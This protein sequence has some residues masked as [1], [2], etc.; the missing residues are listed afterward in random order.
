M[1][2]TLFPA[3][4]FA[5]VFPDDTILNLAQTLGPEIH[6]QD[7][8]YED[9]RSVPDI[10]VCR[11]EPGD[12]QLEQSPCLDFGSS[13]DAV[14]Q[15]FIRERRSRRHSW[16]PDYDDELQRV[17]EV[18]KQTAAAEEE[19]REWYRGYHT[20]TASVS[21]P[22]S[23]TLA[24]PLWAES[25]S[26]STSVNAKIRPFANFD[27]NLDVTGI[28]DGDPCCDG[29]NSSGIDTS[30]CNVC[31][32]TFCDA[33][34]RM[35]LAHRTGKVFEVPHERTPRYVANTIRAV[36][37]PEHNEDNCKDLHYRDMLTSWFGVFCEDNDRPLLRDY[38]RFESLMTSVAESQPDIIAFSDHFALGA[39]YPSIVSFVGTK[40]AGK[41]SLI[42]LLIDLSTESGETFDTPV[43]GTIGSSSP[44][45]TDVHLYLDPTTADSDHPILYADCEGLEGGE[46][47]PVG[48]RFKRDVERQARQHAQGERSL[49]DYMP[50]HVAERELCWADA[51]WRRSREYAVSQ[52][53]PRLLYA[54][55]DAIV[56]VLK[57]S[58]YAFFLAI[59]HKSSDRSYRVVEGVL[60]RLVN[61]AAAALEKSSNQP[62]LPHAIIALNA[63]ENG[64]SPELW[65]VDTATERL[66]QEM[67]RTV[68]QNEDFKKFAQFWRER[69]RYIET[70]EQLLFS[71]YSSIKV[72]RIPTTGR[73]NLIAAQIGKLTG[74]I[75][76]ACQE[77]GRGKAERR[78]LLNAEDMPPYLQYAFDH[79][80]KNLDLPFDF[81]QAS[82]TNSPIPTDFGGNILKLAI[83]LMNTWENRLGA[84]AIFEEVAVMVASCIMLDADRQKI[85]GRGRCVNVQSGH[86]KGH[87]S[88]SGRVLAHGDYLST[89]SFESFREQFANDVY[90]YL[91]EL[92]CNLPQI[93]DRHSNQEDKAATELHKTKVLRPF[94]THSLTVHSESVLLSHTVCFC[95]LF[96][97][98][99]H[100]LPCGHVLC[101]RCLKDYGSV[102]EEDLIRIWGCPI[103][104]HTRLFPWNDTFSSQACALR[105]PH[106][107]VRRVSIQ[108]TC[109]GGI[110]GISELGILQQIENALGGALP[111][112]SFLD[113][114]VGTSTG[115]IISLGLA[116]RGWSVEEC[117]HKF[118]SDNTFSDV[119]KEAFSEQA[120]LFGGESP[121]SSVPPIKVAVTTAAASS[122]VV[123]SNYNRIPEVSLPYHFERPEKASA[124][125]KIWEAARATSA[126]PLYFRPF[127]HPTTKQSYHD[128]GI[129]HNNPINV[130]EQTHCCVHG[131]RAEQSWRD[132]RDAKTV[133]S[134]EKYRYIRLNTLLRD[135]LPRLDDVSKMD[136][137]R[138]ETRKQ[139][140][141]DL[142]VKKLARRLVATS[143][144]FQ[145]DAADARNR[146]EVSVTDKTGYIRCRLPN[147]DPK[148]A[149][150]GNF[151]FNAV[152]VA[153]EACFLISEEGHGNG[154]LG[155][156]KFDSH[157]LEQMI[158]KCKFQLRQVRV[159]VQNNIAKTNIALCYNTED[160]FP[161]SG[162]PRCLSA[163]TRISNGNRRA[164]TA[165]SSTRWAAR[166]PSQRQRQWAPAQRA[167]NTRAGDLLSRF[168]H[169]WHILGNATSLALQ[170][171]SRRLSLGPSQS[172]LRAQV[173]PS[174]QIQELE[175]TEIEIVAEAQNQDPGQVYELE[176]DI[177]PVE[178]E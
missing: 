121:D 64:L 117:I 106:F 35:Q 81:V 51:T 39:R 63:S 79:F 116:A 147:D 56:F 20:G 156:I 8:G 86:T 17:F 58:K 144:Y 120:C 62:V 158:R 46:R 145:P 172:S 101:T 61:W 80:S 100:A 97:I 23:H 82:F 83:Q 75:Q 134:K 141:N 88:K 139:F 95:C 45:S 34:W 129:Y 168:A 21:S 126:A 31:D 159:P 18:S 65:D 4:E 176:G 25:N 111:I 154:A 96:D 40:G 128:G 12:A 143:F 37:T 29:C 150:L 53:Y 112:Q 36:F 68:Y 109:V 170:L 54:F 137:L 98:P 171:E 140:E 91:D 43:V 177:P 2:D 52:L 48:A 160:K 151:I 11:P 28:Q 78:M 146:D 72:V 59:S 15:P 47:D 41:S 161:I 10:S 131:L 163:D 104:G 30:Y 19:R 118:E 157:L 50:R 5:S 175:S 67:S 94:F 165:A 169:E 114:V 105:Y 22:V 107:D 76:S 138:R 92:L 57:N 130:A 60:V 9:S 142:D 7:S 90:T 26:A 153:N 113:L 133:R 152:G 3:F 32:Y 119:L 77:S 125:L 103:D 49:F 166:T 162:F 127:S 174:R 178:L 132:Y 44:T 14:T 110:R 148:I 173:N 13:G 115:G 93:D 6:E 66:M 69:G 70:V 135:S 122:S 89:F 149:A 136:D 99:E 155:S 71:Y 124:E 24:T 1:D 87:Q 33:C 108:V 42:K 85:L 55:S 164:L 74:R 16:A 84:Q 167:P 102:V 38:G 73:P 123:L 27:N